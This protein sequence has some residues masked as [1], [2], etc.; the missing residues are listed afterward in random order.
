MPMESLMTGTG[1]LPMKLS[2]KSPGDGDMSFY[3]SGSAWSQTPGSLV[4]Q[5]LL[6][7][8]V[9]GEMVGFTNETASHKTLVPVFIAANL[10]YDTHTVEIQTGNGQTL[11]DQN[12]NFQ[13]L[14]VS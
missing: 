6:D 13:V 2:F 10:T 5:L 3:L 12:D 1:P 11:T 9:I 4:I 7:G 14:L 8:T